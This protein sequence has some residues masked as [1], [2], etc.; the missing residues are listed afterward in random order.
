ERIVYSILGSHPRIVKCLNADIHTVPL[1]T[2]L[3]VA[4]TEPLRLEIAPNGN[5]AK[6]L[7]DRH[8]E[9][10]QHL[11]A[12]WGVQIAEGPAFLYSKKI[13]W[14]DCAPANMLLSSTL[15]VLLCDFGG[16]GIGG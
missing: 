14:A 12:K 11:R 7:E 6:Y 13:V 16:S 9:V 4:E 3:T 10:P 15:D 8:Q 5:L 1:E 2:R